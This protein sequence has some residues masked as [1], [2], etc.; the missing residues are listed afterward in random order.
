M[1]HTGAWLSIIYIAILP[2]NIPTGI[3]V[4]SS[5]K[6]RSELNS[7]KS[8]LTAPAP[9]ENE[10]QDINKSYMVVKWEKACPAFRLHYM[11]ASS[12]E[13]SNNQATDAEADLSW[14]CIL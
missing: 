6:K 13:M 9:S 4:G 11:S 1:N 8:L 5:E 14:P 3:L 12:N 2:V 10:N 7:I